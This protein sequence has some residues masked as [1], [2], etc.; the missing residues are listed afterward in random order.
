[1]WAT[2][3]LGVCSAGLWAAHLAGRWAPL[4]GMSGSILAIWLSRRERRRQR[5]SA[6][7]GRPVPSPWL[8]VP[9]YLLLAAVSVVVTV[10]TASDPMTVLWP[11]L[12]QRGID[13][14]G[15]ATVLSVTV[16]VVALIGLGGLLPPS[17]RLEE[18]PV[19]PHSAQLGRINFEIHDAYFD[20]DALVHDV[21]RSELR[22][23]IYPERTRGRRRV[24]SRSPDPERLP[25][26]I[27]EL[28]V[29]TVVGVRV[30][31]DAEIGWFP[32]DGLEFDP[33]AGEL[34]LR[35][36]VPLEITIDVTE[37]DVELVVP[38]RSRSTRTSTSD[39]ESM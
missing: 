35:S 5:E 9:G 26:P 36:H 33:D 17:D 32:I 39:S 37:F 34:T 13:I 15:M 11:A 23:S 20:P 16:A 1:M 4:V 6:V 28:I 21:G 3:V 22:L 10:R 2:I 19:G 38:A 12:S 8:L 7:H 18:P 30:E 14:S 25:E 27:G 29:R 24:R 31:D